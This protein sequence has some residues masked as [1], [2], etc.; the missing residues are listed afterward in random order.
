MIG[1]LV[2]GAAVLL[3]GSRVAVRARGC[4]NRG[5]HRR[6]PVSL[7]ARRRVRARGIQWLVRELSL[8]DAQRG[9]LRRLARIE[10]RPLGAPGLAALGAAL[11]EEN[12]PRARVEWL[13]AGGHAPASAEVAAAD[14]L[15]RLHVTLSPEQRERLAALA[16]R[17]GGRVAVAEL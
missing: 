5:A 2:V 17:L 4:G 9:E 1:G 6:G 8:D 3:V 16:S 11:A 10:L 7:W 12:F 15:E 14:S 13:V